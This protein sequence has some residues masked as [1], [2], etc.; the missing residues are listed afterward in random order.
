MPARTG[1][2]YNAGLR[3]SPPELNIHGERV[4][5]VTRHPGLR[6]GVQT[7]AK[8]YDTQHDPALRDEMTYVSPTTGERAGLSFITPQSHEDLARRH[9][10]MRHWARATCA[11]EEQ[12]A[13]PQLDRPEMRPDDLVHQLAVCC[14]QVP[15]HHQIGT[16]CSS[17]W[18]WRATRSSVAHAVCLVSGRLPTLRPLLA[19]M[20]QSR[21]R[22]T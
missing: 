6:H 18:F 10:M 11:D 7:L 2:A 8:L 12:Y 5:D 13:E 22:D 3:E 14:L 9:T 16:R 1:A 19:E 21:K 15:V 4:K 20:R 17:S